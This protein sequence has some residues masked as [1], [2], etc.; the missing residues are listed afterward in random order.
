MKEIKITHVNYFGFIKKFNIL[1]K[2]ILEEIVIE[3]WA[4]D[5]QRYIWA[6]NIRR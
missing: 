5:R 6:N 1:M 3:T 2:T 4:R